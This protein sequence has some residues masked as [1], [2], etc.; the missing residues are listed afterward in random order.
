MNAIEMEQWLI[1]KGA[2]PVSEEFKKQPWYKELCMLTPCLKRH[3]VAINASEY[4]S[5]KTR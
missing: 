4:G 3:Q 1:S 5:D 2:V